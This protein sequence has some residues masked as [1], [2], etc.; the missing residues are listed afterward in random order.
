MEAI[1]M[2]TTIFL[3]AAIYIYRDETRVY[4]FIKYVNVQK[5]KKHK[6]NSKSLCSYPSIN[7]DVV[8]MLI[9]TNDK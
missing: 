5:T 2:L 7:I 3:P 6:V 4:A 9:L 8:Y 1:V